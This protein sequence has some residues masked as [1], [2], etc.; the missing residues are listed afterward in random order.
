[1]ENTRH[2]DWKHGDW[3][4]RVH[5]KSKDHVRLI[6]CINNG[7]SDFYG[8]NTGITYHTQKSPA[9][10]FGLPWIKCTMPDGSV[11]RIFLV[12]NQYGIWDIDWEGENAKKADAEAV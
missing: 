3:A 5:H 11:G 10:L 12:K 4:G 1:M 9:K 8:M 6:E 2:L 7:L